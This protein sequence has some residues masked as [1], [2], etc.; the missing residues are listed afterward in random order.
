VETSPFVEM[1]DDNVVKRVE[2]KAIGG[3][4]EGYLCPLAHGL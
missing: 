2:K 3:G 4:S 1:D